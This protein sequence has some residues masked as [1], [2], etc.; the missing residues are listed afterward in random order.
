M[1]VLTVVSRTIEAT[2]LIFSGME[3]SNEFFTG[4]SQHLQSIGRF[5]YY[6]KNGA[7][8]YSLGF[9]GNQ[10]IDSTL[11]SA[12][13]ASQAKFAAVGSVVS[14]GSAILSAIG[15]HS[16]YTKVDLRGELQFMHLL[17]MV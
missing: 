3:Y 14:K 12:A 11:I 2:H 8:T 4:Y 13:K 10:Y 1:L 17:P 6:G 16:I 7:V 5:A 9:Y 15:L